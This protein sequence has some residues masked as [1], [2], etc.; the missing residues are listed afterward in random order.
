MRKRH[1]G[2]GVLELDAPA[3]LLI[4]LDPARLEQAL[5]D[6]NGKVRVA[7]PTHE[8]IHGGEI[9]LGP[10]VD[11]DVAFRQHHHARHAAI[12]REVVEMAVQD[13][14][15]GRYGGLTQGT[16]DLLRI[17]K[18]P[19]I[20]KINEKVRSRKLHPVFLDEVVLPVVLGRKRR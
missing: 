4:H 16:V 18:I 14:G 11:R 6:R 17:I 13:R 9:P 15:P 12:G 2:H 10:C 7:R 1:P 20:P 5:H 19:G 3:A 8:N